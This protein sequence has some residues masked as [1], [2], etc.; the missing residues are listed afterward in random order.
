MSADQHVVG[1]ALA[2]N[3]IG[4]NHVTIGEQAIKR[5]DAEKAN[6][7]FYEPLNFIRSISQ[8]AD[9]RGQFVAHCILG[10]ACD[11]LKQYEAAARHHQD[12][13]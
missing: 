1:A 11:R 5:G 8:I 12:A 13:L 6:A 7:Y 4:V 2:F 10:I 3:C 9:E